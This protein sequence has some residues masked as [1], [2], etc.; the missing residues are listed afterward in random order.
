MSRIFAL[1]TGTMA[2]IFQLIA[3]LMA[4]SCTSLGSSISFTDF[5]IPS[6]TRDSTPSASETTAMSVVANTFDIQPCSFPY[7][8]LVNDS[9][10]PVAVNEPSSFLFASGTWLLLA[11]LIKDSNNSVSFSWGTLT[12][13]GSVMTC[14]PLQGSNMGCCTLCD[15]LLPATTSGSIVVL[16]DVSPDV[17]LSAQMGSI[18][19]DF[20]PSLLFAI[21]LLG[22]GA[23]R[24]VKGSVWRRV[25]R[26]EASSVFQTHDNQLTK[27]ES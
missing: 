5:I 15:P 24:L 7:C 2:R 25:L 11:D 8:T 23:G 14:D 20:A 10:G 13:V 1:D 9:S 3:V 22:L 18:A 17:T 26:R 21:G 19:P 27:G 16:G 4:F 6:D 12:S